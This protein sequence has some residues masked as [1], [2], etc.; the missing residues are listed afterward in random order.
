MNLVIGMRFLMGAGG[1]MTYEK[2]KREEVEKYKAS[3]E[4]Q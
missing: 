3:S 1:S 2:Q 4:D